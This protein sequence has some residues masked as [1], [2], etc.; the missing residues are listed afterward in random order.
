MYPFFACA[1]SLQCETSCF[2]TV[3]SECKQR[4]LVHCCEVACALIFIRVVLFDWLK[5]LLKLQHC[6]E[7][8]LA[9]VTAEARAN[10]LAD[11]TVTIFELHL[12]VFAAFHNGIALCA[13]DMNL[14]NAA[15]RD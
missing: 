12:V 8:V 4:T 2:L 5:R 13:I 11:F 3:Y 14:A 9:I 15:I 7:F 10:Q 6:S 1:I